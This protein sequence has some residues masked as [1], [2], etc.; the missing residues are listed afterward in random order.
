MNFR[1][2]KEPFP[3]GGEGSLGMAFCAVR[4]PLIIVRIYPNVLDAGVCQS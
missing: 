1:L 2:Q 3:S 4:N